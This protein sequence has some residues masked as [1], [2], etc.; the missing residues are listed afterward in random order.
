MFL[1]ILKV[2]TFSYIVLSLIAGPIIIF[3]I[4]GQE[5]EQ[6]FLKKK[7][8]S[9]P[10]IKGFLDMP[11]CPVQKENMTTGLE[12]ALLYIQWTEGW[13][14]AKQHWGVRQEVQ[15]SQWSFKSSEPPE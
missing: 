1:I 8:K 15:T 11:K 13:G 12:T 4:T 9:K 5:R 2:K 3:T 7:E 14:C 6:H 10:F